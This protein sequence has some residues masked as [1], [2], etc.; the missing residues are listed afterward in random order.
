MRMV[1]RAEMALGKL[2]AAIEAFR[3]AINR[4]PKDGFAHFDMGKAHEK[5]SDFE[6]A[7]AAYRKAIEVEEKL[8]HPHLYLAELLHY[9]NDKPEEAIPHYE[10][11]L[12]LGGE[13]E[14]KE[15]ENLVKQLKEK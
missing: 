2:D 12:E 13:D 10:R 4:D 8:T 7:E 15:I 5:K 9:I 11:Y 1:G 3:A 14:D 6:S